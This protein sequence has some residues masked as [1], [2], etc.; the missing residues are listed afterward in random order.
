M[1]LSVR[2]SRTTILL[3][4]LAL[5]AALW[6][7]IDWYS[8][9]PADAQATY[10][11]RESCAKCHQNQVRNWTGS[12][13]DR[14]MELPTEET[15][16]GDFNNTSFTRFGVTTKFF[17]RDGKY[18]VNTE[19]PDGEFQDFEIKYTFGIRPL[20]QYMVEFPDGRVQVLRVTWDTRKNEWFYVTPSDVT[21][22]R[23][24]P[25]DPLHWTGMGQNWNTMC[26]ECHSTNVK[27]NYDLETDSYNTT[28]S[29][30][31]VS[32]ETC[33]GPGSIHVELAQSNS[34]FWDRVHGY[35]LAKLKSVSSQPE[36]ETCAPCHS[37]RSPVH[38][39]FAGGDP[40]LDYYNPSLIHPGLYY[41]DGQILDEVYVYGSFLQS[42]MHR[43]GV[44]CTDC[45]NAH[46]L[47]LKYE[48][49]RLC[50]QCHQPGKYD[51]PTHHHH[52][53]K[54]ATQCVTCHMPATTY[55][56]I[57]DRRD[58]SIRVPRPDL[59]VKL[60]TPNVCNDCHDKPAETAEWAAD[61]VREWY[62]DKR[63][64]DPH[65][66][67]ALNA[68]QRGEED[69]LKLLRDLLSR[70]ESP[71]IIRATAM[72]LLANYSNA[73][74][75]RLC[76]E[77]LRDANPLIRAA[78]L[79]GLSSQA[80]TQFADEVVERLQDSVR[81]V[82]V[83]VVRRL[84]REEDAFA[85]LS[86]H[87]ELL[88]KAIEEYVEGQDVTLDRG[89]THINLAML[90]K[91][92]G[93]NKAAEQSLATA[94]RLE[95]YLSGVRGELARMKE[96]SGGDPEEIRRLREE[97]V[98]LMV[99]DSKFMPTNAQPHYQRGMLLYLLGR[100]EEAVEAL[101]KA[102]EL[103][104]DAFAYWVALERLCE[105]EHR[106]KLAMKALDNLYR[107]QPQ[108]P[109][110]GAMFQELRQAAERAEQEEDSVKTPQGDSS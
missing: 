33:H 48:G 26:A 18:F 94:I 21:D 82:R 14:A 38:P 100:N 110:V 80:L 54:V 62:G 13:H 88:E 27:K 44:R 20:Q 11:G 86:E 41:T 57:D 23:I 107:L 97:E 67:V 16:L 93:K 43:E 81:L 103:A 39:E 71:G 91:A 22:E 90:N 74:S 30:I 73:E 15:V 75:D 108:N 78:A 61:K 25:G 8:A 34:L 64:D 1:P 6:A 55:M 105:K 37:R 72:E 99:R 19:G 47:K 104:P 51:S 9:L 35:G 17:R 53:D 60:G 28:Y 106:W 10:V 96:D 42:R 95:P 12:D 52:S 45:H 76:R 24:E 63:P 98:K 40:Y 29:E 49:N 2:F 70:K 46:S 5:P 77:G 83:A 102:C 84:I 50:A 58:H 69:G 92:L 4:S 65:Y 79:E 31:D 85:N 89:G 109:V 68:A 56:N 59:T 36:I 87:R 3:G 66:A 101:E 7:G 32:C